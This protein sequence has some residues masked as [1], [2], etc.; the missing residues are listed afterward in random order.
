M[1]AATRA[2]FTPVGRFAPSP[3]GPLH[4]GSL[5]AALGSWLDARS[6]GGRWWLRIE[7]IDAPRSVPGAADDILRTLEA[8][9][10]HWDGPVW[11]QS[12]RLARYDA[13]LERLRAAG[14]LYACTCSRRQLLGAVGGVYPGTCRA[15][16]HPFGPRT[17]LRVRTDDTPIAFDDRIR[18]HQQQRLASEVGDFIVRRADGFHAYQLVVVIDDAEQGVTDVV[19]GADLLDSTARQIHLQRLLGYPTPRYAHLPLAVDAHG[20]KLA[21]SSSAPPVDRCRPGPALWAALGFLHQ[22]PPPAL[23]GA[24]PAELLAWAVPAWRPE[25]IPATAALRAPAP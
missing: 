9:A 25:R 3:T 18:G 17:A 23:R 12:A 15:A 5:V 19:R 13:E 6:V 2:P 10:L 21:K 11:R 1:P 7:D 8:C 4:F 22:A 14:A 20:A 16:A 24:S